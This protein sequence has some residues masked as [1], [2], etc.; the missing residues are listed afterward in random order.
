MLRETSR[1]AGAS[2]GVG[3][4]DQLVVFGPAIPKAKVFVHRGEVAEQRMMSEPFADHPGNPRSLSEHFQHTVVSEES[5]EG[6]PSIRIP[7]EDVVLRPP[8]KKRARFVAE[9]HV[10]EMIPADCFEQSHGE[11]CDSGL[12]T[13]CTE[14]DG[15]DGKRAI[16]GCSAFDLLKG[17]V[18]SEED[19]R[20]CTRINT[21]LNSMPSGGD[22]SFMNSSEEVQSETSASGEES[23]S[24]DEEDGHSLTSTS[25]SE[26]DLRLSRKMIR[27]DGSAKLSSASGLADDDFSEEEEDEFGIEG[28]ERVD[29]EEAVQVRSFGRSFAKVSLRDGED[30]I[31]RDPRKKEER[32]GNVAFAEVTEEAEGREYS[33]EV[34][35]GDRSTDGSTRPNA[36]ITA[37]KSSPPERKSRMRD[38]FTRRSSN[39]SSRQDTPATGMNIVVLRDGDGIRDDASESVFTESDY[40]PPSCFP[41]R[42]TTILR[43]RARTI[44]GEKSSSGHR[45]RSLFSVIG[46]RGRQGRNGCGRKAERELVAIPD[47]DAEV[48]GQQEGGQRMVKNVSLQQDDWIEFATN[49]ASQQKHPWLV[50]LVSSSGRP[51]STGGMEDSGRGGGNG[52]REGRRR[53]RLLLLRWWSRK[54]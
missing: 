13:P 51:G 49:Q 50:R 4:S 39:A 47:M 2:K 34:V 7:N 18:M 5:L 17:G 30:V 25:S 29:E 3:F 21:R 12:E 20:E 8:G 24:E 28:A 35:E 33:G 38:T 23:G 32:K 42:R 9:R 6:V 45:R 26:E 46:D 27:V 53:R 11:G 14:S 22:F 41:S 1:P 10:A 31:I 37:C 48:R 16:T 52:R 15:S 43:Q 54:E 19:L 44:T 36:D 40:G